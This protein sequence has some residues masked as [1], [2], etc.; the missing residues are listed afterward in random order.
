MIDNIDQWAQQT[1]TYEPGHGH[2]FCVYFQ[3]SQ[4]VCFTLLRC[5]EYF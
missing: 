2:G 3:K 4:K 5:G 1:Q